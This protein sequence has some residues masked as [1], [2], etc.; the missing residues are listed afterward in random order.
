MMQSLMLM[1][2]GSK[3]LKGEEMEGGEASSGRN[4][5]ILTGIP[6]VLPVFAWLSS[7]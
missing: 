3:R 2:R 6:G 7:E 5:R 1:M 4:V